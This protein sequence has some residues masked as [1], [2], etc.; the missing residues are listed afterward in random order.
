M[1]AGTQDNK[2]TVNETLQRKEL[3]EQVGANVHLE[4]RDVA[5][6]FPIDSI[7]LEHKP[8]ANCT[9]TIDGLF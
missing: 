6:V 5:H 3:Y 1:H 9:S 8:I 7:D 2:A 4:I